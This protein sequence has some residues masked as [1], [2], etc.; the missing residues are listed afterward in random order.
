MA[1]AKKKAKQQKRK[2]VPV[3]PEVVAYA[4]PSIDI[5]AILDNTEQ[6]KELIASAVK[7]KKTALVRLLKTKAGREKLVKLTNKAALLEHQAAIASWYAKRMIAKMSSKAGDGAANLAQTVAANA[8]NMK[9]VPDQAR[10]AEAQHI[11]TMVEQADIVREHEKKQE[12]QKIL[13]AKLAEEA[14]A[15][16]ARIVKLGLVEV[17]IHGCV[18]SV[19]SLA[20]PKATPTLEQRAEMAKRLVRIGPLLPKY[21]MSYDPITPERTVQSAIE[22]SQLEAA[23]TP[24]EKRQL[25]KDFDANRKEVEAEEKK[26]KKEDAKKL[27][28]QES[29]AKKIAARAKLAKKTDYTP[30]K[31]HSGKEHNNK[32]SAKSALARTAAGIPAKKEAVAKAPK[33]AK[34]MTPMKVPSGGFN[35]DN[36]P[37]TS[38]EL[39][40]ARIFEQKLT[41][42]AIAAEVRKLWPGRTTAVTDVRWNRGQMIAHGVKSV[43][44]PVGGEPAKKGKK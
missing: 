14:A 13:T 10:V 17:P 28:Y 3:K 40:R 39:I 12:L 33:K 1:K 6:R 41:D 2:P 34:N 11:A 9:R 26:R 5:G 29:E 18:Y 22:R 21:I 25:Q 38:G 19:V 35:K 16:S 23:V 20:D 15:E 7:G 43:P 32:G 37:A 31:H 8:K 42:D 27:K 36:R 44:D 4:V 24:K 30:D